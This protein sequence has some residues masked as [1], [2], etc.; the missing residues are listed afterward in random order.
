MYS[1]IRIGPE[2]RVKFVGGLEGGRK[3]RKAIETWLF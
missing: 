2:N 1:Q 3:R